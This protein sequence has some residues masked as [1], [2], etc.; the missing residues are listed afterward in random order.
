MRLFV[1]TPGFAGEQ[2]LEAVLRA[3]NMDYALGWANTQ[4]AEGC[5]RVIVQSRDPIE[6]VLE[7]YSHKGYTQPLSVDLVAQRL[8]QYEHMTAQH[9]H[10][11][12]SIN[13]G[14]STRTLY[15][16]DYIKPQQWARSIGAELVPQ[17]TTPQFEIT[18]PNAQEI[19][20]YLSK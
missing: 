1:Y 9:T 19:R 3:N 4:G 2:H 20:A 6:C 13:D 17:L 14:Y 15:R 8:A 12:Y 10:E 5:D 11:L 16:E 18:I 7:E